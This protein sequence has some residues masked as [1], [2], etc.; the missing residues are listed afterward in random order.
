MPATPPEENDDPAAQ[1]RAVAELPAGA[2][3]EVSLRS[4]RHRLRADEPHADGSP[5]TGP[6]PMA[7]CLSALA[8]CTAATLRM[9]AE[10]KGFD[11]G[12]ITVEVDLT[13]PD[14]PLR[15]RIRFSEPVDEQR[16]RRLGEIADRTPVTRM[17]TGTHAITN[18]VEG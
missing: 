12:D 8:G 6:T 4:G 16:R 17:L 18:T 3:Y 13:D 1:I 15:R 11:L 7:L 14:E 5:M 10:R 2:G 9:Y